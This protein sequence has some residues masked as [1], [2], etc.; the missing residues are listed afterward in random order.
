M[1]GNSNM[2]MLY[3]Y[4]YRSLHIY[5]RII[6]TMA[7]DRQKKISAFLPEGLLREATLLEQH[8]QTD[9]L[10]A[11]LKELVAKHKRIKALKSLRKVRIDYDVE[12]VRQ[13]RTM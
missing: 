6:E 13:R 10:I 4:K 3:I 9:T 8:N 5:F 12:T 2:I 11:A 1:L 7:K